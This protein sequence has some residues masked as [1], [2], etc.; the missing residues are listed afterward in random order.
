MADAPAGIAV[1]PATERD[2]PRWAVLR[3]LLWPDAT[4]EQHAAELRALFAS[5]R[6]YRGLLAIDG[7]ATIG[8]AEVSLRSDYVNGCSSSPVAFLEGVWVEPARRQTGVGRQ[9]VD[10]AATWVVTTGCSEF[11]ADAL[12]DNKASHAFHR[13]LGFIET[14]RVVY[15]RKELK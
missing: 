7:V 1:M 8:F 10:A 5:G 11:A 4:A 9:L 14:D 12:L 13:A 2:V 3:S 15:F 6:R